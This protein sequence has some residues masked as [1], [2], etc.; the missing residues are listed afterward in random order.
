MNIEDQPR[1]LSHSSIVD[2]LYQHKITPTSQRVQVAEILFS[3]PQHL[4]ADQILDFLTQRGYA[5]SRATVY[6]TLGL[7]VDKELIKT[8]TLDPDRVLYDSNTKPHY[9]FRNCDT[10]ELI[11]INCESIELNNLPQLPANTSLCN[12]DIV[13]NLKNVDNA[14]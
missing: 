2:L 6:N 9:H 10:G 11:D 5:I 8:V 1:L 13:L 14:A 12:I 7:F 4:S 3:K